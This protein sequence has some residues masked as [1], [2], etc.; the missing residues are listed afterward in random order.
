MEG[1]PTELLAEILQLFQRSGTRA[2]RAWIQRC[3]E[4]AKEA[5][6]KL[7]HALK[8][9]IRREKRRLEKRRDKV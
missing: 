5:H 4:A 8:H 3:V 1:E 6:E 2:Y 7:Y 9:M